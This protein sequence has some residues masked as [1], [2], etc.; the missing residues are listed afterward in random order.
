M[1]S[2]L[3]GLRGNGENTELRALADRINGERETLEGLITRAEGSSRLLGK[4]TEPIPKLSE[5]IAVLER[6]LSTIEGRVSGLTAVQKKAEELGAAQR[7]IEKDLQDRRDEVARV[8]A[9]LAEVRRLGSVAATL[10]RELVQMCEL[11]GP[12]AAL[13]READTLKAGIAELADGYR[14]LRDGR[15]ELEKAAADAASRVATVEQ[16]SQAAMRDVE[17]Y[18][19]RV[20]DFEQRL[21]ELAEVA[22]RSADTKHQLLTLKSLA[23]QVMQKTAALENQRDAVERAAK[24]VSRLD[25]LVH[26][27]DG[28]IRE[29]EEQI[30]KLHTMAA[31]VEDLASLYESVVTRS[32]TITQQQQQ[33]EERERAARQRLADLGEQLGAASERFETEHRG[34]ETVSHEVMDLRAA[35]R[36]CEEHMAKLDVASRAVNEVEVK[37]DKA[38]VRLGFFMGE[39]EKLNELPE[40]M[41]VIRNDAAKL[42]DLMQEVSA[43]SKDIE[44]A[45][46]A[47]ETA[48][49]DL[50]NLARGH[51]A[52][53]EALE[54]MRLTQ[55][56][57]TRVRET[58]V[59]TAAWLDTVR[60][61]MADL[62]GRVK[63]IDDAQPTIVSVARDVERVLK[64]TATVA[65]HRQFLTDVQGRLAELAALAALLDERTKA[66]RSRLDVAE[67]RFVSVARQADDT[68]QLAN[69]VAKFSRTVSEADGRVAQL[70]QTVGSLETRT[71]GLEGV[72]ERVRLL[73]VE[74][75]QRQV[76][77]DVASAQLERTATLREE[78]AEAVQRL[79]ERLR[80][81]H[82][83]L[84]DLE[85][86][87]KRLDAVSAELDEHAGR[88]VTVQRGFAE[89]ESHL[90]TWETTQAD[91]RHSLDQLESRRATVDVLRANVTQMFELAERTADDLSA[92]VAAQREIRESR[93][94]LEDLLERLHAADEASAALDLH[95]EEIDK[96]EARLARAQAL[97][98]DIQSSLETLNNQKAMLDHVIEQAGALT[99]QIQQAEVLIDRL[100]KERDITNAVRTSL[101]DAGVR[102]TRSKRDA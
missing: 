102:P 19:R 18:A 73:R 100:R 29:Q 81:L 84:T 95:R 10:K 34:L 1:T 28:A 12:F 26:Q 58:Q 77:L 23:D 43:R 72:P 80:S 93:A 69:L 44:K 8:T 97:L 63:V 96:A 82:A 66:F 78:A 51:E 49:Q 22:A 56:E 57:M 5:R 40:R 99:F 76:A 79:D 85:A 94:V 37:A 87:G 50:S 6:Q 75:E 53:K 71:Q 92:A 91:I 89:F 45:K 4:I 47:V 52:I 16:S 90:G 36:D 17:R 7:G 11:E 59:G 21:A 32:K 67:G 83:M 88:L 35:V 2:F 20:E 86:R 24:D 9:E 62:Q 14:A 64:D 25:A 31:D 33:I 98:F 68:E 41:R 61:S 101:E 46:P 3:K 55:Q 54:E 38:W 42:N 70:V 27:V 15:D 74:L 13:R 65:S 30:A 39:L 48:A 60:E